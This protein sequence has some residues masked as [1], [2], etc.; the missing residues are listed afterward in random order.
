MS[1]VT[2]YKCP[3]CGAPM[4]FD[5][6]KQCMVCKYCTNKYDLD[7]MRDNL[8]EVTEEKLSDFDWVERTK[9]VWEPEEL[10]KL[11]EYSCPS[12]GSNIIT[13]SNSAVAKCPFCGHDII[14]TSNFDGDIRP[15]KVIT[16][17]KTAEDFANA[18][19]EYAAKTK[20]FPAELK[21]IDTKGKVIG[22]YI[23]IWLYNCSCKA[24]RFDSSTIE[25]KVKDY[26]IA[27]T[28]FDHDI[29]YEIE[30]FYYDEADDFT[31]SCLT[32]FYA[33]RYNIGA[34]RAM[35]YADSEI[36]TYASINTAHLA[37]GD[38]F[39]GEDI[40]DCKISEQKLTYYLVP[41]WTLEIKFK[42]NIYNFT[43]NG[44]TGEF[45][46]ISRREIVKPVS[47]VKKNDKDKGTHIN[48]KLF[49]FGGII[50]IPIVVIYAL[51]WFIIFEKKD[52]DTAGLLFFL[53][54][55]ATVW[56]TINVTLAYET[57]QAF[58]PTK[59]EPPKFILPPSLCPKKLKIKNF[60]CDEKE[61]LPASASDNKPAK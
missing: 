18:Y 58:K 30:P 38:Y 52:P 15:D 48:Y 61:T 9:Y 42:F 51:K 37:S 49:F 31:E 13:G 40:W 1:D 56:V 20:F 47:S 35:E 46:A 2:E 11:V 17:R 7:Y 59:K 55:F 57:K 41:V 44:Q 29:F 45:F 50:V 6:N 28:E 26:P 24:I 8:D 21:N 43:M 22:R 4:H 5:I 10:E 16:F 14:I 27:G 19:R 39:P 12:C 3:T 36:K 23:P 53:L 54:F 60:I 34:E 32:G 25:F 33:S